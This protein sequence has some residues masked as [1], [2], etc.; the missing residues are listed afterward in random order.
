MGGERRLERRDAGDER[1]GQRLLLRQ[2]PGQLLAEPAH[3]AGLGLERG[4]LGASSARL[5]SLGL[6]PGLEPL[7]R[8]APRDALRVAGFL[9]GGALGVAPQL[10][11]REPRLER[12][13]AA[14]HRL[15]PGGALLLDPAEPLGER[16]ALPRT[17]CGE[18]GEPRL[19]PGLGGGLRLPERV[20]P[21][22]EPVEERPRLGRLAHRLERPHPGAQLV[23]PGERG[24]E[25]RVLVADQ[26]EQLPGHRLQPLL[27]GAGLDGERV[28]PQPELGLGGAERLEPVADA[29]RRARP[30]RSRRRGL[31]QPAP[32]LPERQPEGAERR[33]PRRAQSRYADAEGLHDRPPIP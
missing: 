10:E 20:E 15:E 12:R 22:A 26:P 3:P 16:R 13:E 11:R 27:G 32:P 4:E 17:R 18:R 8:L 9:E 28:E 31:A 1:L 29:A 5:G 2:H 6:E 7:Q 24:L 21:G 19:D 23:E 25:R 33:E 30:G 14:E